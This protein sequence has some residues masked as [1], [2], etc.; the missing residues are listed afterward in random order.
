MS[1]FLPGAGHAL[2]CHL[3]S[4][5]FRSIAALLFVALF[6]ALFY[7]SASRNGSGF[8]I[9]STNERARAISI[10]DA[11]QRTDGKVAGHGA[12]PSEFMR[13][14][15]AIPDRAMLAK[16]VTAAVLRLDMVEAMPVPRPGQRDVAAASAFPASD[17]PQHRRT[18]ADGGREPGDLE[19]DR[20]PPARPPLCRQHSFTNNK[21]IVAF[22]R[23]PQITRVAGKDPRVKTPCG[24]LR[25]AS[26]GVWF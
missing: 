26:A 16:P 14:A 21:R 18:A 13:S 15:A 3:F 6:Y 17:A 9:S 22:S 2:A 12:K 23:A 4:L 11:R 7:F 25:Y 5:S 20:D 10:S 24:I 19:A 1:F 8:G